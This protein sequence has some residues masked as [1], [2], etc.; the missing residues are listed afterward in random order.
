MNTKNIFDRQ[1]VLPVSVLLTMLWLPL[2]TYAQDLIA[3]AHLQNLQDCEKTTEVLP[4]SPVL[5]SR[6]F[7]EGLGFS[8]TD[9]ADHPSLYTAVNSRSPL[10][11]QK[12]TNSGFSETDIANEPLK[13]S[14]IVTQSFSIPEFVNVGFSETDPVGDMYKSV[15][16]TDH[17][18]LAGCHGKNASGMVLKTPKL[19]N[20]TIKGNHQKDGA[21]SLRFLACHC[22][23]HETT[24]PDH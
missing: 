4:A 19:S 24:G 17:Q 21:V 23:G 5:N 14:G 6:T 20:L 9:P 2:T 11:L 22:D 16:E 13:H 18:S 8:E 15:G 1:F 7:N 3:P 10:K 12:P